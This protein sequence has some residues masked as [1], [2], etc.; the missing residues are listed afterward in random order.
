MAYA[1]DVI[2]RYDLLHSDGF[3]LSTDHRI[4]MVV[5]NFIPKGD[6]WYEVDAFIPE[7]VSSNCCLKDF[8]KFRSD[9]PASRCLIHWNA[10]KPAPIHAK[11]LSIDVDASN[12]PGLHTLDDRSIPL[13]LGKPSEGDLRVLELFAGGFG[14][15]R[16]SLDFLSRL[17][18]MPMKIL[19]VE[20]CLQAALSFAISH[21]VPLISGFAPLPPSLVD[22]FR[23]LVLHADIASQV[24]LD[25]LLIGNRKCFVFPL[26][27]NHGAVL[28]QKV[29]WTVQTVT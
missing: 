18:D 3:L 7:G 28:V 27:A 8:L 16:R 22:R 12:H 17:F 20:L 6:D 23:H 15:W 2:S 13:T 1:C 5:E 26:L 25:L 21:G 19:S 24:W 4:N 29:A 10:Q 14:G 11:F 9:A